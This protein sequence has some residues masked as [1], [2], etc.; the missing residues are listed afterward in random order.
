MT[1][2]LPH[3][4][5]LLFLRY[6][7]PMFKRLHALIHRRPLVWH[8]GMIAVVALLASSL[9]WND[10]LLS[11]EYEFI[12]AAAAIHTP[13]DFWEVA[14]S[15]IGGDFYRPVIY[16]SF[17]VDYWISG[18]H[19]FGYHVTNTLLHMIC[20]V[21]VGLIVWQICK[22]AAP[23]L[24]K[25]NTHRSRQSYLFAT[26]LAG[27][28][29]AVWP[30]HHEA[31]TWLA[32]RTD[33]LAATWY[34]ATLA[35][36]LG[37]L[38]RLPDWLRTQQWW[39][40]N[41]SVLAVGT[42]SALAY[43]S[44]EMSITLI[45]VLTGAAVLAVIRQRQ[46]TPRA[47]LKPMLWWLFSALVLFTLIAAGYVV[48]RHAFIGYWFGGYSI[49]GSSVFTALQGQDV[50]LWLSM[51]VVM[52]IYNVNWVWLLHG[53]SSLLDTT[54]SIDA[55]KQFTWFGH[56]F[57]WWWHWLVWVIFLVLLTWSAWRV[58]R[59]VQS[60]TG[61]PTSAWVVRVIIF[62]LA[63]GWIYVTLLP[64][65]G[66]LDTIAPNLESTRF[67][68]LP[69]AG[70]C[71]L[72]ALLVSWLPTQTKR[73]LAGSALLVTGTALWLI[74]YQPWQL[75]S[76]SAGSITSSVEQ[77]RK[78]F[79][80]DDWL[81]VL[82]MPDNLYGAYVFRRG[83]TDMIRLHAPQLQEQRLLASGRG[84]AGASS[85]RCLA[86]YQDAYWLMQLDLVS[87]EVV[88]LV[89]STQPLSRP[90]KKI[91][92]TNYQFTLSNIEQIGKHR[93]RVTGQ[94]PRVTFH[95][96]ERDPKRIASVSLHL[97][98]ETDHP[99]TQQDLYWTTASD[100]TYHEFFRHIRRWLPI[101]SIDPSV[102]H[103]YSVP[104]CRYP[105]FVFSDTID[106]MRLSLPLAVGEEFTMK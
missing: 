90:T 105:G 14:T 76:N 88:S 41:V 24:D 81:Y 44:K 55:M 103:R 72:L 19:P 23:W 57:T 3:L 98:S 69:S 56:Q 36:W 93:F 1:L 87:G 38:Q 34:L 35:T 100:P 65:I 74:N 96:I 59:I 82:N 66:I 8:L 68:Y 50:K 22:L 54:I 6:N 40:L 86:S 91:R 84:I 79:Y 16:V 60:T 20:S 2:Y 106:D 21:L 45:V 31:V 52:L 25:E 10:A 13:A 53:L 37:V 94:Q 64:V 83:L 33:L 30:S 51:P 63:L 49:G 61:R 9:A 99:W 58:R 29:F 75:A 101:H 71:G 26:M 80:S 39:K 47:S 17:M 42:L 28:L 18:L 95:R 5:K 102:S 85:R 4:Y 104:V 77:H 11:D 43:L 15:N 27:I 89:R 12:G 48:L 92:L 67:F 73:W 62:S 32:A 97:V 70:L 7:L 78:Q 46:L